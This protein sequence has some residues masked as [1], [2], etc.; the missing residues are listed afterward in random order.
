MPSS[1]SNSG[2]L[3]AALR[4]RSIRDSG[5]TIPGTSFAK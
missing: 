4:I 3:S 1:S 5:T 2:P